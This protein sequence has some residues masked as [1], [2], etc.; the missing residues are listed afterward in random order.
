[1]QTLQTQT[2]GGS[3][4]IGL[5]VAKAARLQGAQ[6]L[7]ASRS[8]AKRQQASRQLGA[9]NL[10]FPVDITNEDAVERLAQSLMPIDHLV[11]TAISKVSPRGIAEMSASEAKLGSF[12]VSYKIRHLGIRSLRRGRRSGKSI[13]P[14]KSKIIG[15]IVPSEKSYSPAKL[16]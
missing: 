5:A 9:D 16:M 2:V 14:F 12:A 10:T 6:V 13:N 3:E 11:I 1:M 15:G 7:I 4:G 8:E